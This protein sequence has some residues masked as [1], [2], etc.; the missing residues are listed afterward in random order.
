M[1][2][3]CVM[4]NLIDGKKEDVKKD[5]Q[6]SGLCVCLCVMELANGRLAK[7]KKVG[8]EEN[9]KKHHRSQYRHVE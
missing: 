6:I 1:F 8:T 7:L 4:R 5:T 3:F 2:K 9:E